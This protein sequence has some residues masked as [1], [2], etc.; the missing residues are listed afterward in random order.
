MFSNKKLIAKVLA[1]L[2]AW[3]QQLIHLKMLL[4]GLKHLFPNIR[5][6]MKLMKS[7]FLKKSNHN[8]C[9]IKTEVVFQSVCPG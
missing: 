2:K 1:S 6:E 7:I 3:G 4:T 5:S 9:A 8:Y